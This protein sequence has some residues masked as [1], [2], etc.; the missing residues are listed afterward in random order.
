MKFEAGGGSESE[1]L[2]FWYLIWPFLKPTLPWDCSNPTSRRVAETKG[3]KEP[4]RACYLWRTQQVPL[5][6][7]ACLPLRFLD[8][9][10]PPLRW[11][12]CSSATLG[13]GTFPLHGK[14]RGAPARHGRVWAGG[15]DPG[16]Q[17]PG[18]HRL[19]PRAATAANASSTCSP[20]RRVTG[21]LPTSPTNALPGPGLTCM[22]GTHPRVC[23]GRAGTPRPGSEA[24]ILDTPGCSSTCRALG[25]Q[26]GLPAT[27]ASVRLS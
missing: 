18:T 23:R 17:V 20:G 11:A 3:D 7:D 10:C 15:R 5:L 1:S 19:E 25:P 26:A 14:A 21:T 12:A 2:I 13:S 22:V 16:R 4:P 27:A 9:F 24:R 6:P 8:T